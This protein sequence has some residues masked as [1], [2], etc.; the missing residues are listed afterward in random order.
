MISFLCGIIDTKLERNCTGC[1]CR[2]CECNTDQ[3]RLKGAS[4]P[5]FTGCDTF[6]FSH[7]NKVTLDKLGLFQDSDLRL[8]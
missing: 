6:I 5:R 8:Q 2:E 7:S 1:F 4:F 3:S